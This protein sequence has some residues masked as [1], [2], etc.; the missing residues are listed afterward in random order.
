M[1]TENENPVG[2]RIRYLMLMDLLCVLLALLFAFVIRYEALMSVR[3]YVE[4]NGFL[5]LLVP[6]VRLPI[7]YAFRLYRRL[8]R[9]ASIPEF[10]AILFAGGLGSLLI[11]L[12][13]YS[14][15]GAQG[16][17]RLPPPVPS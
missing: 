16:P 3:P 12:A 13:H 2:L 1:K 4:H 7:Y 15:L 11:F 17:L 6:L 10:Q 9:Y 14:P 5:F 8:W